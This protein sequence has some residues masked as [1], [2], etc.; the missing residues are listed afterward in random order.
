[1]FYPL[2]NGF[3]KENSEYNNRMVAK[4]SQW[5]SG[6]VNGNGIC[7]PMDLG[8]Y[9]NLSSPKSVLKMCFMH[10]MTDFEKMRKTITGWQL[11]SRSAET[12]VS[13]VAAYVS[14]RIWV[15]TMIYQAIH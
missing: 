5:H 3:V 8:I 12:A 7:I 15:L 1:V 2:H 9:N 13:A 4:W 6:G 14:Q 10:G 11:N